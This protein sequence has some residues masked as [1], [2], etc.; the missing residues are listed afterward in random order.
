MGET[1]NTHWLYLSHDFLYFTYNANSLVLKTY[2]CSW[3][4]EAQHRWNIFIY[5]QYG[6]NNLSLY[7]VR[8]N[9]IPCGWVSICLPNVTWLSR[10]TTLHSGQS[11]LFL[12]NLLCMTRT[13][14]TYTYSTGRWINGL[15]EYPNPRICVIDV[16]E[17]FTY[18]RSNVKW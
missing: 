2:T 7:E 6:I 12:Q 11:L 14:N 10:L 16:Q 8:L 9:P 13:D 15:T 4:F 1:L 17:P 5:T 3:R 18:S